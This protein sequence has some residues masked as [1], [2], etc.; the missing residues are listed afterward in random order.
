VA[1]CLEG[2]FRQ[3]VKLRSPACSAHPNPTPSPAA[4]PH[5]ANGSCQNVNTECCRLMCNTVAANS[6]FRLYLLPD[7]H[8]HA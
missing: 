2:R 4:T 1:R 3:G 6:T 8:S 7:G 5:V